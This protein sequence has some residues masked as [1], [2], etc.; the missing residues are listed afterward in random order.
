MGNVCATGC[1]LIPAPRNF[2][3]TQCDSILF[4]LHHPC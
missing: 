3:S 2:S 4:E 1:R